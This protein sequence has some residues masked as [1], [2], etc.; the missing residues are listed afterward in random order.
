[1]TQSRRI[2]IDDVLLALGIVAI[3]GIASTLFNIQTDRAALIAAE[4]DLFYGPIDAASVAYCL[5]EMHRRHDLPSRDESVL[6]PPTSP[7]PVGP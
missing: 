6:S 4:C 5:R 2:S 7:L 3:L 1:M